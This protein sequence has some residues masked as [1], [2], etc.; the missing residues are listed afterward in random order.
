M[1]I[2]EW[3]PSFFIVGPMNDIVGVPKATAIWSGPELLQ[4]KILQHD[5]KAANF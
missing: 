5:I 2:P 3:Y 1:N 4:T